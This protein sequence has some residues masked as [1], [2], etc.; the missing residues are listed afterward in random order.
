MAAAFCHMYPGQY[1]FGIASYLPRYHASAGDS[2]C[3]VTCT[4]DGRPPITSNT[5]ATTFG[6]EWHRGKGYYLKDKTNLFIYYLRSL[7]SIIPWVFS[8]FRVW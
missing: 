6:V 4:Y 2:H 7:F 3:T 5:V 1:A 8:E